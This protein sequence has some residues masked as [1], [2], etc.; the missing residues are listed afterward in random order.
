MLITMNAQIC[1]H[2]PVSESTS[3]EPSYRLEH[4]S[5][6]DLLA[7]TRRL[8]GRQNQVLAELLA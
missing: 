8:V 6:G 7:G 5:D 4:I 1:P 2:G 3:A